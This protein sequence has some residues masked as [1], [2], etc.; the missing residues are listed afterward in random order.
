MSLMLRNL[1]RIKPNVIESL[2]SAQY[3]QWTK[4]QLIN[5][6]RTLKKQLNK[7]NRN[8]ALNFRTH[9]GRPFDISQYQ[10]QR[11]ALKVAYL[12]WNY[13]GFA[14]QGDEIATPTVEGQIFKAMEHCRLISDPQECAYTRCGRTD[15]GVSGLGQV[16]ALNVRSSKK[17]KDVVDNSLPPSYI[18]MLNRILPHDIRI[19]AWAQVHPN[20]NARFDC[21]SRTYKYFFQKEDL[22]L[23]LMRKAGSYLVGTHD[24][25]NFCRIDPSKNIANY[26]RKV[27]SLDINK[28]H[29]HSQDDF[30]EVQ[31]KGSAFLWNQ[32]RNIMSIM[33]LVGQRLESPEIARDLLDLQKY[34]AK[35]DYPLA[36]SLPL[37]LYDCEFD[38]ISWKY[39]NDTMVTSR[40]IKMPTPV[41]TYYHLQEHRSSHA[42]K[43]ILYSTCI[44]EVEQY[45]IPNAHF[46]SAEDFVKKAQTQQATV[47]LGG[48][49]AIRTNHYV[50]IAER[51]LADSDEVKKQKYNLKKQKTN[52]T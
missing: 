10:Q 34:P 16:I 51:K 41:S 44:E 45:P 35:P 29:D 11:I 5:K 4:A 48:G 39:A 17:K 42:I 8:P 24:F 3:G 31:L 40:S 26:E 36:D 49:H 23:D 12:G 46:T 25:R 52:Q 9:E 14:Y 6:I 2:P 33:F 28:V 27:F 13:S 30:Y 22:D 18:E 38:N 47:L 1:F 37:M 32:V 20:F 43:N 50:K 7:A 15:K 21:K 19:L